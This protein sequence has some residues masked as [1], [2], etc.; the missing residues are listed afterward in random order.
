[1]TTF[2]GID[3]GTG[4]SKGV[5]V[6]SA[7]TVLRQ[8][9]RD[10]V[11][12]TP[13]PGWFEHDSETVWRADLIGI[14]REL[15]AG[16][17][18]PPSAVGVS[19]IGPAV[20][21]TDADNRPLRPAILY[22]IDTRC[23]D[24]VVTE[25]GRLGEVAIVARAGNLMSTQS[26]GPKLRWIAE[27][28]PEVWARARR[29]FSAPG[30]LVH[31]LTGEY[32]LDRYSASNSDPL[33][34]LTVQDWW[35]EGWEPFDR[36]ERPRLAWPSEIVG[37]VTA[38]AAA[39][40][41]LPAGI[42]V[43]TGTIDALAEAYSVGCRAP[44]DTMVMYGST[45]F[46]VQV[47][48]AIVPSRDLWAAAGRTAETY[49]LS[50]GMSTGGL[51]TSWLAQTL[52]QDFAALAGAAAAVPP[53]SDGLL[54]LPYFAGERT[55]IFDTAARASWTGLTLAH[56]PGHLYRSGLEGV[57]LGVRHNLDAMA[58]AGS[59]PRRLVAV[60]G[61]TAQRIWTQIV[62]DVTG[63]PQDRPALTVGA[64]FGDARMAADAVG[65]RT[66]DWN[67][68]VERLMPDPA[69]RSVYDD[70]YRLYLD[71]Y[72]ALASTMHA[73]GRLGAGDR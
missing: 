19:G 4:S 43:V 69:T 62:S 47:A 64:S 37:T 8:A 31:C 32:T 58:A 2:L 50:G 40:T 41:G 68:V 5:L 39:Q 54:L 36:L 53:G 59:A 46:M 60:G 9:R 26:V 17:V 1:M 6:D 57:A 12:A 73:L 22:G 28:E 25:T 11:T 7:G 45:M 16:D 15:L 13:Q 42:P 51:V 27:A 52:G 20:L 66:S 55:P 67:P 48:G 56:G 30:W 24:Q 3:I 49:S 29:V 14:C 34:D 33:Y 65:V 10:H 71:A 61:G 18:E 35:D 23:A 21:V 44:G 72:P 63:L 38:G 70:L